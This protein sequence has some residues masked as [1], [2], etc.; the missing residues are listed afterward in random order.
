MGGIIENISVEEEKKEKREPEEKIE[1]EKECIT[2]SRR[3]GRNPSPL[4]ES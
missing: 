4:V 3:R 1:K 2:Y